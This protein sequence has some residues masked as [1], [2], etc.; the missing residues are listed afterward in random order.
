MGQWRFGRGAVASALALWLL[1]PGTAAVTIEGPCTATGTSSS[2]SVNLNTATEWHL[3]STDTA[4]GSGVSD[5]IMTEGSVSAYGLG[6]AIPI[7]GGSGDGDL[8]GSVDGVQVST[9]AIL[10]HRF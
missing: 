3:R 10:G 9:Y 2:G 6:I 4:G 1:V 5:V 7:V 8:H